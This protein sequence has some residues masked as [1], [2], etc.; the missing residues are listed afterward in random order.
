M[1]ISCSSN[2]LDGVT[3]RH[4]LAVIGS[5]RILPNTDLNLSLL[6][7]DSIEDAPPDFAES[8]G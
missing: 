3:N 4:G 5:R 6:V 7:S 1:A 2:V 8:V